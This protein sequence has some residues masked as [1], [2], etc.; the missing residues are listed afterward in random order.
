[1]LS[2]LY[3]VSNKG[4][5]EACDKEANVAVAGGCCCLLFEKKTVKGLSNVTYSP[6]HRQAGGPKIKLRTAPDMCK[7]TSMSAL[8]GRNSN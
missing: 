5:F 2:A 8:S 3:Y 6:S 1:M 4:L 7:N